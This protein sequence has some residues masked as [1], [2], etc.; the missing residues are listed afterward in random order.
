MQTVAQIN[1]GTIVASRFRPED[2]LDPAIR[3]DKP[4]LV[5]LSRAEPTRGSVVDIGGAH[6]SDPRNMANAIKM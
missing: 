2:E 6:H 1:T 5:E 4:G 3:R